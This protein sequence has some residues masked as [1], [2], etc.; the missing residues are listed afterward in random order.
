MTLVN[1]CLPSDRRVE[2]GVLLPSQ[3]QIDV[4]GVPNTHIMGFLIKPKIHIF[5]NARLLKITMSSTV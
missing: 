3:V 5:Q 2:L 4:D 1:T